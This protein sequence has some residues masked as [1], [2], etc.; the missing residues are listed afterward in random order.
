MDIVSLSPIATGGYAWRPRFGGHAYVVIAKA[1]FELAPGRAELARVQDEL[2]EVDNH[3]NDDPRCSLYAPSDLAPFKE[4][5]DVTLV[6]DAHAPAGARSITTRL[7]VGGLDK[8][9]TVQCDRWLDEQ[10]RLREGAPFKRMPLRYERAVASSDNPVGLAVAPPRLA[11]RRPLP[12]LQPAGA[13]VK[14]GRPVLAGFGP[15]AARWP[16]RR[17]LLGGAAEA[18]DSGSWKSEPLSEAIDSRF[19]NDAPADQQLDGLAPDACIVLENLHPRLPR[20]ACEL[21]GLEPRAF[22]ER[23]GVLAPVALTADTLWIDMT[24]A[25]CTVTWRGSFEIASAGEHGRVLVA[26]QSAG[27]P[28]DAGDVVGLER[29]AFERTSAVQLVEP[30]SERPSERPSEPPQ[31]LPQP[32]A[33]PRMHTLDLAAGAEHDP[34][35]PFIVPSNAGR[36]D[37]DLLARTSALPMHMLAPPAAPTLE[38]PLERPAG[39][40]VEWPAERPSSPWAAGAISSHRGRLAPPPTADRE[41]VVPPP[42]LLVPPPASERVGKPEDGADARGPL[43]ARRRVDVLGYDA[44]RVDRVREHWAGLNDEPSDALTSELR[45]VFDVAEPPKPAAARRQLVRIMAS[46]EAASL[47]TMRRALADAGDVDGLTQA[48]LTLAHG[49]LSFPFDELE[50]LKATIA[51]VSPYL[52]KNEALKEEVEAAREVM[53]D[54]TL[55]GSPEVSEELLERIRRA[56]ADDPE[57]DAGAV[58][59]RTE[60]LLLGRRAYQRRTLLGASWV[61]ALLSIDGTS[62]P[63]Y[64]PESLAA[65][66]PLFSRLVVRIIGELYPRQDQYE[67]ATMAIRAVALGR[68]VSPEEAG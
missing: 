66:T 19:F 24:R 27:V 63:C 47:A 35:L 57:V 54:P 56:Y 55:S 39:L 37:D 46:C 38:A 25:L 11:S 7:A 65:A 62:L 40:S 4:R 17:R 23:G 33:R 14:A 9:V 50:T 68:I 67:T 60:R 64:L 3:W 36:H 8:R 59:A 34:V 45:A 1:T 15:L 18:F 41:S 28:L 16:A 51:S 5:V 52:R 20:L 10:G 30:P 42:L 31:A 13:R 12:N 22:V 49:T 32:A 21:P 61:R 48:P 26:L 29:R 43:D 58:E 53:R 6:G 2:N 44:E